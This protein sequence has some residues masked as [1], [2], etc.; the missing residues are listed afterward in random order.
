MNAEDKQDILDFIDFYVVLG[1]VHQKTLCKYLGISVRTIQRWRKNGTA[2]KRKGS[3][4]KIPRKLKPE[5]RRR[6]YQELC[7]PEYKDLNPNEIYN[8]LLDKWIYLASSRTFYRILKE[9]NAI[10]HR[11]EERKGNSKKKPDE[12]KAT[13]P[14]QVWMWDITWVKTDVRGIY[15]YAYVIEDLYDRSSGWMPPHPAF[16]VKKSVYEKYGLF[17]LDCGINAGYELMLRFLGVF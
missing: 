12:L 13:A 10:Y 4:R 5:E 6:I 3:E 2:D 9:F 14:N 7:S 11:T 1:I 16:F 17:R 8:S 15:Y